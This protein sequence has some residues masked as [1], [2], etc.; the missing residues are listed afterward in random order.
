MKFFNEIFA[1]NYIPDRSAASLRTAFKKFSVSTRR[2]FVKAALKNV[3]SRFSHNFV[4]VP[5]SKSS[6]PLSTKGNS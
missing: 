3:K 4:E 2:S 5:E 1:K 6:Q